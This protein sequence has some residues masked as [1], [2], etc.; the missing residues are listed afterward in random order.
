[1]AKRNSYLCLRFFSARIELALLLEAVNRLRGSSLASPL[2]TV[3]TN[4]TF[5]ISPATR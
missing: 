1:M 2:D 5:E 3:D 4:E